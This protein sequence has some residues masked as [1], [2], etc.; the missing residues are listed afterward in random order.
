M[1]VVT[2]PF[3]ETPGGVYRLDG[4]PLH[5]RGQ[6]TQLTDAAVLA[7]LAAA[8]RARVQGGAA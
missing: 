2:A 3:D 7:D 4:V 1:A 6:A 5:R 8:V